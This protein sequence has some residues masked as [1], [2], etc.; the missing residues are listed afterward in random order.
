MT[1]NILSIGLIAAQAATMAP[2]AA[3]PAGPWAQEGAAII[4]VAADCS[5]AAAQVVG[6]T[7]GQLLSA[8]AETQGG[9]VVCVITVLVAGDGKDRPKKVTETRAP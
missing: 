4:R 1:M 9:Q 5:A 8:S 7:G 3:V 6:E 2:V